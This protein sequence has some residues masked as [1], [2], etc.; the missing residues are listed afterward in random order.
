MGEGLKSLKV[1]ARAAA[2]RSRFST[3]VNDYED[4]TTITPRPLAGRARSHHEVAKGMSSGMS[5]GADRQIGQLAPFQL[6]KLPDFSNMFE[7]L[8][9]SRKVESPYYQARA[10][11]T[12]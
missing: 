7:G 6:P 8:S 2:R 3:P 10:V 5:S 11:S 9:D 12:H 1:I 4:E